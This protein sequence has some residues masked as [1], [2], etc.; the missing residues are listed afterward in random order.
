MSEEMTGDGPQETLTDSWW[1]HC[2][3]RIK[4]FSW[5]IRGGVPADRYAR[6]TGGGSDHPGHGPWARSPDEEALVSWEVYKD[7]CFAALDRIM[8][9]S[10]VAGG[11]D[12]R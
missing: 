10:Q 3:R 12:A 8:S 11:G 9:E 6:G 5:R 4:S 2:I 1:A 7:A